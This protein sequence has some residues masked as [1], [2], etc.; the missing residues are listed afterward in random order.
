VLN[1]A[2]DE[3]AQ[4]RLGLGGAEPDSRDVL[5]HLVV[6]LADEFPI[7]RPCQNGPQVRVGIR[8]SRV[9][10]GKFLDRDRLQSWHQLEP[11]QVTE[12]ESDRALAMGVHVL[13]IDF[14]LRAVMNHAFD[15]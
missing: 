4:D 7:D 9:G 10:S 8:L 1:V 2:S 14:H 12:R 11:Q 5:D 6:L 15:H 3:A 13:S